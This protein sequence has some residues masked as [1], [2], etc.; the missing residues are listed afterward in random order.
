MAASIST[1]KSSSVRNSAGVIPYAFSVFVSATLLFLIQPIV[2]KQLLP[3]FGGGAGVWLVSLVFFQTVLLFG[4]WYA[5]WS[6]DRLSR[7]TQALTHVALLALSTLAVYLGGGAQSHPAALKHP[8][9]AALSLLASS[10]GVPYFV[11]SSTSPLLQA[12]YAASGRGAIPYRLFALSNLGSLLALLAYPFAIEPALDTRVQMEIWRVAYAVFALACACVAA[13]ALHAPEP[14]QASQTRGRFHAGV[15]RRTTWIL[16]AACSSVL[17]LAVTNELCQDI[18]PVPLLWIAPLAIYLASFVLCF[19]YEGLFWP[20]VYKLLVPLALASAVFVPATPIVRSLGIPIILGG[21]FVLCMFCHGQLVRLKPESA[22]LTSFYLC[23]SLGGALGGLFAGLLA[24]A[25]FPDYFELQ[26]S[27]A[28][29]LVL[30][31]RFLFGYASK[32]FLATVASM[33]LVVSYIGNSINGGTMVFRGR[34]FYGALSVREKSVKAGKLRTLYHGRIAHGGQILVNSLRDEPGYYYGRQSGVGLTLQSPVPERRVGVVGLG[35]GTVAA[36]GHSGDH[37]RFY[38]INPMVER[39]ARSEFTFL[40]DSH[41]AVE[42]V[43]GDARLSLEAEPPQNFDTLILDAFSGDSIPVHL[44]T[45][46]A[47][48]CYFRHLKPEG[49]IA[50]H[51]SNN[52]MDLGPVVANIAASFGRTAV[53]VFSEA[54]PEL[55]IMQADWILVTREGEFSRGLEHQRLGQVLRRNQARLWTDQYSNIVSVIRR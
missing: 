16:L 8:A 31:L 33:V 22:G 19:E 23:V 15:R 30:C 12:W 14:C 20:R 4:Y 13:L 26:V 5:H 3:W 10:I 17:L 52:Y 37:Y 45:R 53:R 50:V 27:V 6:I 7:K 9:L 25:I 54:R 39:L 1:P 42:T 46:E 40:R 35:V 24:P 29:G 28:I 2:A 38:E 51:V 21:F 41:A 49:A 11:L 34:N 48:Q 32:P 43:L 55:E 47:F 18:A 44:L 36:Y